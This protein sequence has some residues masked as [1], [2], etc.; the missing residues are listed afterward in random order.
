MDENEKGAALAGALAVLI[1][2]TVIAGIEIFHGFVL[3]C[4]WNWF[5]F[6]F[7]PVKFTLPEAVGLMVLTHLLLRSPPAREKDKHYQTW[8]PLIL[9]PLASLAV[10]FIAHLFVPVV[11]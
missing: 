6:L 8:G 7:T 3:M 4:V 11:S 5:A 9:A 1:F 10:A 2:P